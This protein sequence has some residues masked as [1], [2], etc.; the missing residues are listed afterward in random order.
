MKGKLALTA[1]I[2]AAAGAAHAIVVD[3][4]RDAGYGAALSVQQNPTQFGDS[5]LGQVGAANGSELDAGYGVVTGGGNPAL[6]LMLTG[7]VESNFNKLVIFIDSIAGGMNTI[8]G[9]SGMPGNY[10]GLTFDAGFEADF[11]YILNGDGSTLYIDGGA[12]G[13][14][15]YRGS[16]GYA[17]NGALS[18]GNN[19]NGMFATI[20][21][22]NTAGVT[23]ASAAGAA[24]VLTGAELFLPFAEI[25]NPEAFRPIKITAFIN[26]SD[27]GFAANQFLGSLP[28]GFNNMGNP[29]NINLANVDGEQFFT[30]AN[31]VPEPGTIAALG[32]GAAALLRRRRKA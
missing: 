24:S 3:G 7:N 4:T 5:N 13:A 1:M 15:G 27:H 32:L 19:P 26:G 23:N 2:V 28:A 21:N 31:P 6:N 11:A 9:S 8:T 29:Q 30:V 14:F 25:G 16:T 18:G 10:N 12:L 22:S 17:S 20:N